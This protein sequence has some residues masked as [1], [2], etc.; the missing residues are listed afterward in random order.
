MNLCFNKLLPYLKSIGFQIFKQYPVKKNK[1]IGSVG[2]CYCSLE[3][4]GETVLGYRV[5][6]FPSSGNG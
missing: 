2:R 6:R 5:V 3:R 1:K 4:R